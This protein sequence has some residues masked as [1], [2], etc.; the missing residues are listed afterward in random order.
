MNRTIKKS[1]VKR[2]HYRSHAQFGAQLTDFVTAYNFGRRPKT[3]KGLTPYE[4]ICK[5]WIKEPERFGLDPLQKMPGLNT[6]FGS[7][8]QAREHRECWRANFRAALTSG[9]PELDCAAHRIVYEVGPDT[10][11]NET[12]GHVVMLW[13]D[14]RRCNAASPMSPAANTVM[15]AG[16]GTTDAV[17]VPVEATLPPV[18]L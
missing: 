13:M 7:T 2:Y 9:T 16:S 14:L 6:E 18:K 10:G 1:T 8:V 4:F 3:L 12:A 11:D 17:M 5:A 15:L